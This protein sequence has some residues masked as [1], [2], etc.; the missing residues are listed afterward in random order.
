MIGDERIAAE[1]IIWA[2]GVQGSS[3]GS[4]LGVPTEKNGRVPV[5][6]DLTIPG[7]C[8]VFVVGDLAKVADPQTDEEVPGV[9]SAA[10]QMGEYVARIIAR[11]TSGKPQVGDR[12]PFRYVNKGMLATIGRGKAVAWIGRLQFSGFLAWVIWV[13]VHIMYL[14]GFRNRLL[15]MLQWAWTY[16]AWHRG[17]R[18]ITGSTEMELS[19]PR[20]QPT[21]SPPPAEHS[22]A[23]I[24]FPAER[25][26][27]RR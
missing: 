5:R 2:A 1:N 9:A 8:N 20:T 22:P 21:V 24:T 12:M 17:A 18:I 3:L 23:R 7:H 14:I 25:S 16:I 19:L 11:E 13:F 15:V 6:A 4:R 10:I 27:R 26:E